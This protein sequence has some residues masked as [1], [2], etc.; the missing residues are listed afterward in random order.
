M[1]TTWA[2]ILLVHAPV[3]MSFAVPGWFEKNHIP[4]KQA[5][6]AMQQMRASP[7]TFV[8]V[9]ANNV[10]GAVNFRLSKL[11][12]TELVQGW[13]KSNGLSNRVVIC[14][15]HGLLPDASLHHGICHTW[16]G[17]R[18]S[19]DDLIAMDVVPSLYQYAKVDGER[20]CV[21]TT[22]R[23]LMQRVKRAAYESGASHGRLKLL[24]TRKFVSLLFHAASS[25]SEAQQTALRDEYAYS[26]EALQRFARSQRKHRRHERLRRRSRRPDGFSAPSAERTWV[27]VAMAEKLRRLITKQQAT[28][29]VDA[30]DATPEPAHVVTLTL[31]K[32]LAAANHAEGAAP[33]RPPPAERL[34]DD[35]RLDGKQRTILLRYGEALALAERAQEGDDDATEVPEEQDPAEET[36]SLTPRFLPTKRQRR[37]Q[38]RAVADSLLRAAGADGASTMGS[39]RRLQLAALQRQQQMAGLERWLDVESAA[40]VTGAALTK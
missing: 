10:R 40:Q 33:A 39:D 15:D 31:T 17:P 34:L 37:R 14:W 5:A 28:S 13:A 11:R 1:R 23:E 9:D 8:V 25:S 19:A 2:A 21:V 24:G 12:L 38:H 20:V 36:G 7:G 3:A 22:D 32:A 29:C 26:E 18:H 35:V 16:A 6:D 27:R 30:S 4:G